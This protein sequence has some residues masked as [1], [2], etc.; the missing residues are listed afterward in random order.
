MN[1]NEFISALESRIKKYPDYKEIIDY[2]NELIQDKIDMNYMTEDEAVASLGSLDEI[3][4]NIEEQRAQVKDE[5]EEVRAAIKEENNKTEA[6]QPRRMSGGK[7]FV[8][9][10]WTIATV[11]MAIFSIIVLIVAIA[12]MVGSIAGMIASATIIATSTSIAS[13][14]FGI[15]LFVFGITI[16]GV[17]YAGVLVKFVFKNRP[18]WT[19]N[20]RKGL[21][22]E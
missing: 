14:Y 7:R 9:V 12:S 19:N 3:C 16:I 2:Y 13:F 10:L 20:V 4:K 1:K 17:H 5:K 15:G 11:F 18:R 22:G 21:E 6:D 8:Y